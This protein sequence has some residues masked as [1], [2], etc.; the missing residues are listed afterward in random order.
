MTVSLPLICSTDLKWRSVISYE[1]FHFHSMLRY[2]LQAFQHT[3]G[4]KI[5]KLCGN[6]AFPQIFHTM[7]LGEISVFFAVLVF[8]SLNLFLYKIL[9]AWITYAAIIHLFKFNKRNT[10][11]RCETCSNLNKNTTITSLA[12]FWCFY[13]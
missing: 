2:C 5:P 11:K 7:K 6:C 12:L 3:S 1:V 10:M 9:W 13:C 8:D 4:R